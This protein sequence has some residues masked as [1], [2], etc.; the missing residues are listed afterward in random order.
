MSFA[1]GDTPYSVMPNEAFWRRSI[2]R[3]TTPDLKVSG[4]IGGDDRVM[5]AGSCFAANILPALQRAGIEYVRTEITPVV[6]RDYPEHF[7]YDLFSAAYGNVYTV[8]QFRQLLERALGRFWPR[9][10]R[11]HIDGFVIDLLRP[12]LRFPAMSDGEFDAITAQHLAAVVEAV[13]K[14]TVLVFTLGLTEGW[15]SVADGTVYPA[16][17]GA[18]GGIFDPARFRFTNFRYTSIAGDL[19][20]SR[21]LIREINPSCRMI[22]TVSPVPLV[23]TASGEHVLTATTYS[24]SVLRAVAGD[25]ASDHDDVAYFPAYEIMTGPQ[26]PGDFFGDDARTVEPAA[27]DAVMEQLLGSAGLNHGEEQVV[28]TNEADETTRVRLV[29]SERIAEAECEEALLDLDSQGS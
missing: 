22:L 7:G 17:P 14:A 26:A 15:E 29:I 18:V 16:V 11:E 4:L 12:G 27:V 2:R 1:R 10:D 3:G 28:E 6:F 13:Q 23:A 20:L 8:R 21:L 5:S 19:A 24:K 9:D 25:L